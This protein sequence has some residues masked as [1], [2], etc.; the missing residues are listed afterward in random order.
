MKLT[1]LLFLLPLLY[2]QSKKVE[3]NTIDADLRQLEWLIG[4]WEG[5]ANDNPFYETWI[6]ASEN[7]LKNIN[8]TIID[9]D[10]TGIN[11]ASI[12]DYGDRVF[13]D[14]GYQLEATTLKNGRVVFED[15]KEGKRYEFFQDDTGHWVAKLK[16]G[17]NHLQYQLTK[18]SNQ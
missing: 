7:E 3:T 13:Y 6:K 11:Y 5:T 15:P 18:I 9:G 16:N 14:N 12:I 8:Y 1:L 4:T 2:C 17:D 10:T